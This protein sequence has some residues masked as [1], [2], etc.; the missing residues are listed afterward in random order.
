MKFFTSARVGRADFFF[1][2]IAINALFLAGL[3]F[4]SGR[5][6][7]TVELGFR[8]QAALVGNEPI[9]VTALRIA[10][11]AL[12]GWFVIRRIHDTGRPGWWALARPVL[13]LLLG[14]LGALLSLLGLIALFFV[15]GTIGPNAFGPDPRGW[16][17]REQFDEQ[18]RRLRSGE[19]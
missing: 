14:G 1:G 5:I 3:L 2:L 8:T 19:L 13:P 16:T 6:G 9:K 18:E 17:S 12:L 4:L 11:D 10:S 15:R 7:L